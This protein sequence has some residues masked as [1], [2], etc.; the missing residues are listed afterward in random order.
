MICPTTRQRFYLI[1][2]ARDSVHIPSEAERIELLR[3]LCI[4]EGFEGGEG[5]VAS[6][7]GEEIG[8]GVETAGSGGEGETRDVELREL[9]E[10][11]GVKGGRGLGGS[12]ECE[13]RRR[14]GNDFA[15]SKVVVHG[16]A[17]EIADGDV[18]RSGDAAGEEVTAFRER[19]VHGA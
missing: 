3:K 11:V 7:A 13:F 2:S 8:G 17:E 15:E 18:G 4:R 14:S 9:G 19:S 10:F 6:G 5:V 16:V 1:E 12:G